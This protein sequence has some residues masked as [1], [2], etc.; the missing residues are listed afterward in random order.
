MIALKLARVFASLVTVGLCATVLAALLPIWPL[1]LFVHFRVQFIVLGLLAI[2]GT[3][4]LRHRGYFDAAMIATLIHAYSLLPAAPQV[5]GPT[6]G[7]PVR[8]LVLNVLTKSSSFKAVAQLIVESRPDV[9]GLVEVDQRWLDALAPVLTDYTGRI[10][11]PR[12][13]NFGLALFARGTVTGEIEYFNSI[14]PS[15]VADVA[16][17]SASLSVILIHP[18]PPISS[19]A[20]AALYAELDTIGVRARSLDN[21]LV[22]GDFNTTPWSRPYRRLLAFSGLCDSRDGFGLQSTFPSSPWFLRVPIDHLLHGCTI[23]VTERRVERD[24]GSD[25][26][27]IV[28]DLVVP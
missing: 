9:I 16:I 26:L 14:R 19:S 10:E 2:A 4:A 17:G 25:H 28:V 27:P 23:G 3:F 21:A 8:V 12:S 18:L 13:D 6:Q 7:T 22:M 1:E 5:S 11:A 15:I 20:S 24:V